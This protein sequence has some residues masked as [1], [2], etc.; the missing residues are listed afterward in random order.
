MAGFNPLAPCALARRHG[1]LG[2]GVAGGGDKKLRR[3]F[4]AFF[5][6]IVIARACGPVVATAA[7]A[8][9]LHIKHLTVETTLAADGSSVS[10]RHLELV[11]DNAAAAMGMGQQALGYVT[12]YQTLDILEAYT[13]KADGTRIPVDVGA[14]YDQL[15]PGAF[16]E[17]TDLHVK[18]IVFPQFSAGDTA[19]YTARL[20][21][22]HAIFPGQFW[23]GEIFPK[24]IAYD[25]VRETV[26]APADLAL[27]VEDHDVAFD[28]TRKG[29]EVIYSWRYGAAASDAP[30]P[31]S[32]FPLSHVPRYFV[33]T[34]G[35]YS[36][37]GRAY[38]QSA[39]PQSAVT[40]KIKALADSIV[41]NARGEREVV[42]AL[43]EWIEGHV[44]YVAVE[45][46]KGTLVPHA[47]DTILTNGYGDC[48]DHV[49]LFAALMKAEGIASDAVLLNAA[50]DY[51]LPDVATFGV[52]NH[53]ITYVPSL[54][55]FLDSTSAV[56]P[57]G[58]LP[59]SEYGKP[60]VFASDV[61]SRLGQIPAL[62][63]GLAS[64]TTKTD[65]HLSSD[66]TL[67]G[68]T[69]T[70]AAGPYSIML[71]A[72]GLGIQAVG[73]EAAGKRLMTARGYGENATGELQAPPPTVPGDS[74]SVTGSFTAPHWTDQLSG[75]RQFP[76]PG[77]MRLLGLSGDGLMGSYAGADSKMQFEIPC[78]SGE[79]VE[80]ISLEAPPGKHFARVPE[81][82]HVKSA[83][84]A[85][86]AHWSLSNDII[87]VHRHFTSSIAQPFCTA[88]IRE[89]N[90]DALK[91]IADSY[92][93]DIWF[94]ETSS[95]A[96]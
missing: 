72:I 21:S 40:P 76:I 39:A 33:S 2:V 10:T 49:A 55:L 74:Y 24:Q 54:D 19:V 23:S 15:P 57:F 5:A 93:N 41:K 20:T 34:F 35:D 25:D 80:D 52:L 29:A 79:A 51:S 9:S 64:M 30:E 26:Q 84:I 60:V 46:G 8:T 53:V 70:T 96:N 22:K 50:T 1:M 92:N 18:T 32:I 88:D 36:E 13:L 14:I 11:A 28:K 17:F 62:A 12:S 95:D 59:F 56:A 87:S 58:V 38:A 66:G 48:K 45:L 42:R 67:S 47:A 85:F 44:R 86:D 83:N 16:G 82:V 4:T 89:A 7:A 68:T 31:P 69:T 75:A 27:H 37:L 63:A 81:D 94:E 77:G 61:N 43:Y 3:L 65:S 73:S 90:A 6:L 91:T 78:Y 71:R